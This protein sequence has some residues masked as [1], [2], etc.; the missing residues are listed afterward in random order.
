M[1]LHITGAS[2]AGTTTLAAALAQELS[3]P[4]VD[5][6]NYYWIP[7]SPPFKKKRSASDRLALLREALRSEPGFVLSG[8]ICGWGSEIEE[9]FDFIVFLYLPATLRVERLRRREIGA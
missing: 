3:L 2:G 6:D 4:H 7:T 8:S 1:R 5:A 9:A